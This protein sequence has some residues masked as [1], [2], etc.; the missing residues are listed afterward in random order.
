MAH[1]RACVC[2]R[3][4]RIRTRSVGGWTSGWPRSRGVVNRTMEVV[5]RSVRFSPAR[6]GARYGPAQGGSTGRWA[7]ASSVRRPGFE[8][9]THDWASTVVPGTPRTRQNPRD[10]TYVGGRYASVPLLLPLLLPYSLI[11]LPFSS[12]LSV[13]LST[14]FSSS[15][16]FSFVFSFFRC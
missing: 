14:S 15:P 8:L 6:R 10:G 16:C 9:R 11:L 5:S 12:T 1:N 13:P 7:S 3:S 2:R 4:A